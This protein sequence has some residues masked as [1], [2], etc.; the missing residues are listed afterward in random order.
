MRNGRQKLILTLLYGT[1]AAPLY[2]GTF[3]VE[4]LND[5]GAGSLRAAIEAA[6]TNPGADIINFDPGLNGTINLASSLPE[7][8]EDVEINGPGADSVTVDGGTMHQL[9]IFLDI[10]ASLSDLTLSNGNAKKGGGA[11]SNEGDLVINN[12]IM[13]NNFAIVSGGAIDNFGGNL[14]LNQSTLTGNFLDEFGFGGAIANDGAGTVSVINS[15]IHGNFADFSGGAIDN[16]GMLTIIGSTLSGNTSDFG[17]A[18]ENA[19]DLII[20]NSTLSGNTGMTLGGAIDNFGGT[21]TLD[22]STLTGNTANAGGGIG[23]DGT[24]TVKNSLIVN[25]ISGGNCDIDGGSTLNSLGVNFATDSSCAG[26]TETTQGGI[27]LGALADNGGETQTHAL[28]SESVAIDAATDCTL[29]DGTTPVT[30]DQRGVSRPL[31][32][33]CDSGAFEAE[34][35]PSDVFF[36]SGFENS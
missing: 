13:S 16:Q 31:G 15:T 24:V 28:L 34:I 6:N 8:F 33:E 2:A 20:H 5:A 26:F 35:I 3:T 19:G 18:I 4:N 11:V 10:T 30:E 21:V 29:V 27:N 1:L 23:S 22:F 7:I 32:P 36:S 14:T 12:C 25:T 17:G 9:F